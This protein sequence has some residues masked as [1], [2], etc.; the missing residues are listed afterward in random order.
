MIDE[1][2]FPHQGPLAPD[3]VRG[4][5]EL[6]ADLVE[7]VTERRVTA[8]LGPRRYGKTSVLGK[9]AA[10]VEAGGASVIRLDLY[11]T[12]SAAD[13]AVRLD[14]ALHHSRGGL[15]KL[16]GSLAASSSVNLGVFRVEFARPPAQRPDAD[17]SLHLLLD[18]MVEGAAQ[19]PTVL[20]AD[21]FT[22]INGVPGAAALLRTKLQH[23]V[24]SI[25]VLFAGSEPS[26]MTAMFTD[27]AAPFYAQADIVGIP[28][29]S[30]ADLHS[31]VT[32]G[33]ERTGRRA[34]LLAPAIHHLTGGHPYRSM[35]LADAAWQR[36]APG[37]VG[38]QHWA[39]A[40]AAVRASTA[41][42][43]EML[44]S[45][46]SAPEQVVLR[47]IAVGRPLFGGTLE[48]FSVSSGAVAAARDRLV[49][50]GTVHGGARDLQIVDPLMADWIRATLP[51]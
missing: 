12:R 32:D 39:E 42:G 47:A 18:L 13:L 4:R 24:R 31:I 41:P 27:Q 2:P 38:E 50:N 45:T 40:L 44:F 1:P 48:L 26:A 22:G 14:Q 46:Y 25:G 16:L 34:G 28:P 10:V 36:T 3:E 21:E 43:H 7:R 8:L 9:V 19:T 51:L 23:H 5:D 11:E 33:F 37:G 29:F 6:V 20:I 17:A 49:A 35:Q 30:P 15:R